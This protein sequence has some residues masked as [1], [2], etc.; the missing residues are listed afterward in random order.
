ML[1]YIDINR[2]QQNCTASVNELVTYLK[3]MNHWDII[4]KVIK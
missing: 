1:Y 2:C 4:E 3:M